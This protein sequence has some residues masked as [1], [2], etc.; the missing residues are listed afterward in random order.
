M[1]VLI[2]G[3]EGFIGQNLIKLLKKNN[4]KVIGIHRNKKKSKLKYENFSFNLL[5]KIDIKKLDN[6]EVDFVI[7][8]A[9]ITEHN[10]IIKSKKFLSD[11]KKILENTLELS[12]KLKCKY[13]IYA[14]SGKVYMPT[15]KKITID[16]KTA[17]NTILGKA[18]L[19]AEKKIIKSTFFKKNNIKILR[20]FNL[21][22]KNQNKQFLIPEILSQIKKIKKKFQSQIELGNLDV[23]RDFVYI[24][25]F[26][27]TLLDLIKKPQKYQLVT[28]IASGHSISPKYI[29]EKLLKA[30]NLNY[31]IV[32]KKNK[33][34]KE[35]M[36]EY[37]YQKNKKSTFL[38]NV[39][40]LI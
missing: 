9:G 17:P 39:K 4:L 2:T 1:K 8:L 34:R 12:K 15:D 28:N 25:D 18:K 21:Y 24:D 11:T 30:N 33:T 27:N 26:T 19:I 40:N 3:S 36:N 6:S 14:S 23:K 37:V 29:A 20:I 38:Q 13:F 5:K 35:A 32:S 10:K 7:H 31:D 16:S 22:G